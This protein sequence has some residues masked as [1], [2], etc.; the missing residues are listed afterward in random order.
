VEFVYH[1]TSFL[2]ALGLLAAWLPDL[3]RVQH[4]IVVTEPE[5]P[6]TA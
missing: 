2:P 5:R 6:A 1:L 4:T 3:S